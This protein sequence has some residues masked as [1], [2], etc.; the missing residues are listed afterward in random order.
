VTATRS[1]RRPD[2]F[3]ALADPTRRGILELLSHRGVC[4]AG[5]VADVFPD[6]S[7]PAVSRHLR[8]LR[9]SGLVTAEGIGREYRY[10]LNVADLARVQHEWFFKF[11]PIRDAALA[12]LKR[13]AESGVPFSTVPKGKLRN[14]ESRPAP[15]LQSPDLKKERPYGTKKGV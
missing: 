13:Q 2:A 11:T 10:Q 3:K 1:A 5:E 14:R 6:I 9:Q 4:S 12:A 8:V 15:D 7:R